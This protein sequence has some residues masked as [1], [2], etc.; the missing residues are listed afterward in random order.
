MFFDYPIARPCCV[1][2]CFG[3][4]SAVDVR[5][6]TYSCLKIAFILS[7]RLKMVDQ[8]IDE[9]PP[10]SRHCL[11]RH[12]KTPRPVKWSGCATQSYKRRTSSAN[13]LSRL[14]IQQ[15]LRGTARSLSTVIVGA[16]RYEYYLELGTRERCWSAVEQDGVF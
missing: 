6:M 2:I 3:T 1:M 11:P 5:R 15:F 9:M 13:K 16:N 4:V 14:H 10:W 8:P 7:R 12:R